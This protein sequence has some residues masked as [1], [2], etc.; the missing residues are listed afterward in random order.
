MA[1]RD[2]YSFGL[3]F[4]PWYLVEMNCSQVALYSGL[5]RRWTASLIVSNLLRGHSGFC[6]ASFSSSTLVMPS[7]QTFLSLY[8]LIAW[9]LVPLH[10]SNYPLL[11][12][13]SAKRVEN[14]YWNPLSAI[15]AIVAVG[16]VTHS[17]ATGHPEAIHGVGYFL[18]VE[19]LGFGIPLRCDVNAFCG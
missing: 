4:W 2:R 11:V 15:D 14:T 18:L 16:L 10:R 3:S 6:M 9:R 19:T 1:S 7:I 5:R 12:L 17:L 8:Q 13:L